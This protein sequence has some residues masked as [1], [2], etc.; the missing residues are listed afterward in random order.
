VTNSTPLATLGVDANFNKVSQHY[1]LALPAL[2]AGKAVYVEWPL[3]VTTA[4]AVE[5]AS[6]AKSK[7]VRTVVGVRPQPAFTGQHNLDLMQDRY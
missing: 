6:L 1:A 3:V 2:K 7:N 5:L 4:E